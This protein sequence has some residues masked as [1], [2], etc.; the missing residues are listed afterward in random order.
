MVW[1]VRWVQAI[2]E[3]DYNRLMPTSTKMRTQTPTNILRA[4]PSS[5][6][7]S[8][9]GI[10]RS[11]AIGI[12]IA[13]AVAML[14]SQ[15]CTTINLP[16]RTS[17]PAMIASTS[18]APPAAALQA[19]GNSPPS[20]A[21]DCQAWLKKID[22]IVDAAGTRDGGEHRLD[23]FPYLRIDRFIA[24]FQPQLREQL[25][26]GSTAEPKILPPLLWYARDLDIV[27]RE[28][29]LLNLPRRWRETVG[30]A[31]TAAVRIALNRC[32]Q[33]LVQRDL[34][35]NRGNSALIQTLAARW[36]VP[37]HYA[38]W[39]RALGLYPLTSIPFFKGVVGWQHST[40]YVFSNAANDDAA[41]R[42]EKFIRYQLAA[43]Y[44]EGKIGVDIDARFRA[45]VR[46]IFGI[47]QL[48]TNQWQLLLDRHAPIFEVETR[49]V[50]DRIGEVKFGP[51]AQVD[52]ESA[53]PVVYQR[54]GFTRI[55]GETHAQLTYGIWFT[56]RPKTWAGAFDLLGGH[57]DNVIV[58]ITLDHDGRP[59]IVDSIHGCGCYHLFFPTPKL[60]PIPAPTENMEWAF[61]PKTLPAFASGQRVVVGIA[62]ATHYLTDIRIA[63]LSKHAAAPQFYRLK[64]ERELRSLPISTNEF[65]ELN[66]LNDLNELIGNRTERQ[67]IF[68]PNGLIAGTARGE[69]FLFWPMGILSPGAMRQWGTHATAFVGRRH[70]DDADLI[71]KRFRID[72]QPEIVNQGKIPNEAQK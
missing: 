11:V 15:G 62:S 12:G 29:E 69:R 5:V 46:N 7:A 72:Q 33:A 50:F 23:G 32:S 61:V 37:D 28:N 16:D 51:L 2:A 10:R 34:S 40:E 64:S 48:S 70:F 68:S 44:D 22:I 57:L 13:I 56:E 52:V 27:A 42:H 58:R 67:S 55:T 53:K 45:S 4:K 41:S 21:E 60:I 26:A 19:Y 49:G 14:L 66:Q 31:D 63:D 36:H 43:E 25:Q 9:I 38:S 8:W 20:L 39:K 47:P 54:V 24:S 30:L 17:V 18:A 71:G 65:N 1:I 3:T 35:D 59:L 6:V